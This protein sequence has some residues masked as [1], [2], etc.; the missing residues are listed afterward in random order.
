[1]LKQHVVCHSGEGKF[2]QIKPSNE[3][4]FHDVKLATCIKNL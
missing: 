1:M 4:I 2:M 3:S